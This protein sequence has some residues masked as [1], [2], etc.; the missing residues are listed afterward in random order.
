MAAVP[1][2]DFPVAPPSTSF[3]QETDAAFQSGNAKNLYSLLPASQGTSYVP[4]ILNAAKIVEDKTAPIE[5][6][7]QQTNDAGGIGT[8]KGNITAANAIQQTWSEKQPETGFFKG[9]AQGLMG[10]PNWRKAA[11]QGVITSKPIY[12]QN[13]QAATGFFAE[14][15]LEPIRVLEA[16]TGREI[17][18]QEYEQRN[19]NKYSTFEQTPGYIQNNE[20][21]KKNAEQFSNDQE[22][23]NV[24]SAVAN[25][26]AQNSKNI[27]NG[28][29]KIAQ[30]SG[31][32]LTKDEIDEIHS[33]S[34]R[35]GL[36]T[37]SLSKGIQA[38]N[39]VTDSNSFDQN[40]SNLSSAAVEMGLPPIVRFDGKNTFTLGDKSTISRTALEQK[41]SNASSSASQERAFTQNKQALIES[42]VYKKLPYEAQVILDNIQNQ[43]STNQKLKDQ[44]I[45][46]FG[47]NPLF[48][49]TAP[50]QPGQP[51]SVG[52]ANALIDEKNAK[53]A[54]LYREKIDE[55]RKSGIPDRG[56]VF[57][58]TLRDRRLSDTRNFYDKKVGEVIQS[59]AQRNREQNQTT[60][61]QQNNVTPTE[62][63]SLIA[64][65]V[66]SNSNVAPVVA[67]TT[68]KT[69]TNSVLND[70]GPVLLP[71]PGE[72]VGSVKP[73]VKT[74]TKSVTPKSG[75]KPVSQNDLLN[76]LFPKGK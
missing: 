72:T 65:A 66:F 33:L 10:N 45:S 47:Q 19:F 57:Q 38:L 41:M 71:I 53:V 43:V 11:T 64:P 75:V 15:S 63:T 50:W 68:S 42:K 26:V 2:T 40:Q 9:L 32:Q 52:V 27:M 73:P 34:T 61:S 60:N 18:T 67:N 46:K 6:I 55:A 23:A 20:I 14:N 31:T 7:L 70:T 49:D 16:G 8:P 22:A 21:I 28:F 76:K 51:M 58:A 59:D 35:T 74:I 37:Q 1:E 48:T 13:G 4:K 25:T 5:R 12:D 30:M 3:R 44:Y 56:A 36:N 54:D 17:S 29:S 69:S 62:N 39:S 24:G